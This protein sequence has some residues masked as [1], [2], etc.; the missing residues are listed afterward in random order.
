MAARWD[1]AAAW[2]QCFREQVYSERVPED[3]S[4]ESQA[5][6]EGRELLDAHFF[7]EGLDSP[8]ARAVDFRENAIRLIVLDYHLSIEELLKWILHRRVAADSALDASADI[9]YVKGMRSREAI[10]LSARLGLIDAKRHGQL[11]ELNTL[12]NRAGHT[13]ALDAPELGASGPKPDKFPLRW[14]G[15][16]LTPK[17]VTGEF[18]PTYAGIY[19]AFFMVVYDD[20]ED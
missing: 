5:V 3:Q 16:R 13:W 20:G 19:M 1:E 14:K 9:E 11:V 7:P 4:A 18:V 10:D 2:C 12:R 8:A 15:K 17:V 6:R